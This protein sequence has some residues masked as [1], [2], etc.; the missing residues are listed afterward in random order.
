[1]ISLYTAF[2]CEGCVFYTFISC[3]LKETKMNLLRYFIA[4]FILCAIT[5][6]CFA[7]NPLP[8]QNRKLPDGST[9]MNYSESDGTTVKQIHHKDGTTTLVSVDPDGNE[10]LT[11]IQADGSSESRLTKRVL[12]AEEAKG[13]A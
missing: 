13:L 11:T 2:Q 1:M 4:S 8:Y 7:D 10:T 6:V 12:T 9:E 3:I 5:N